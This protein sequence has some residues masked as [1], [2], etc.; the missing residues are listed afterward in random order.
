MVSS[1]TTPMPHS[2]MAQWLLIL[3]WPRGPICVS[4]WHRG[5]D[6]DMLWHALMIFLY[7]PAEML[8]Q[9]GQALQATGLGEAVA[10]C[11]LAAVLDTRQPA[12]NLIKQKQCFRM[13]QMKIRTTCNY[14]QLEQTMMMRRPVS[15]KQGDDQP[16]VSASG[17]TTLAFSV[18]YWTKLIHYPNSRIEPKLNKYSHMFTYTDI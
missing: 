11:V 1:S 6:D 7:F 16:L 8:R 5:R 13:V 18:A 12:T 3:S 4:N 15:F 2:F 17:T 10:E 9:A 14:M